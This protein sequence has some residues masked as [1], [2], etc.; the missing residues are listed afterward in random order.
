MNVTFCDFGGD[1]ASSRL[2][3]IIIRE[4]FKK[5]G[6]KAGLDIIVYGKHVV[7]MNFVK[8]FKKSVYD[9]C[10]DHFNDD[11][12]DYYREHALN[13]DLLV[14]N[15]EKMR[16]VINHETGKDAIVI[17]EPYESEEG[18][19]AID[20]L[21]LWYGH[22]S[23]TKDL[24]RVRPTLKYPVL[25]L[26]NIAPYYEWSKESFKK[27]ISKPCIVIIPTGEKK[28]KSENRMVE[29]IRCGRYVCAE[30][31]PAYEPFE[32]FFPLGNIQDNADN[33]LANRKQSLEAIK[34]AQHYIR[35]KY[36]P[37]SIADR[38]REAL[39][40]LNGT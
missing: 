28:A 2:R 38:W 34:E 26:S 35:Q 32:Q 10:D 39:E 4:E 7:P 19:P 37:E 23:N 12:S 31:L 18:T 24:E 36:S 8:E 14:C 33:A 6:I 40:K 27:A 13:A 1:I 30:H 25:A 11:L 22:G 5:K 16:E 15:S 17:P 3:S 9:I 20:S 21:Y 29:A